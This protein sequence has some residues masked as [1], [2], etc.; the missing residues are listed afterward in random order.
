MPK[1]DRF[2]TQTRYTSPAAA[3]GG[4]A[5]TK[6]NLSQAALAHDRGNFFLDGN[7]SCWA[8]KKFPRKKMFPCKWCGC[9]ARGQ[10]AAPIGPAVAELPGARARQADSTRYREPPVNLYP[11]RDSGCSV[12]WAS[13]PV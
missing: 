2:L 5:P 10:S 1:L 7:F 11:G 13:R 9:C 8:S 12:T 6:I 4:P 3:A